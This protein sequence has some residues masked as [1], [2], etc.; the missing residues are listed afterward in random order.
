MKPLRLLN[1]IPGALLYLCAATTAAEV[2]GA[3]ALWSQGMLTAD[4]ITRYCAVL[5][6]FD[7]RDL[8]R[9]KPDAPQ[10]SRSNREAL[11]AK[12]VQDHPLVGDRLAA[13]T[14]E[15][16]NIHDWTNNLRINRD[17]YESVKASFEDLL[18]GLE[19]DASKISLQE[20]QRT[21]EVL[22]PKQAKDLLLRILEDEPLDANDDVLGDVVE[23]VR[24]MP[25]E[26]LRKI[27][28][29]FKTEA[30]RKTL[31]RILLVIG[32]IG[33]RPTPESKS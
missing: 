29:E 5:Y 4:K 3:G 28:G 20:V 26:R 2:I 13:V 24:A 32:E 17:R 9:P 27:F 10:D 22:R 15:T 25:Q 19:Q 12:R 23:I 11:L 18:N 7:L 8:D 21:L 1:W 6:G 31:H 33:A 30:E 16:G 14:R